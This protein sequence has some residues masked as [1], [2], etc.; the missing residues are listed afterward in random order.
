MSNYGELPN[1]PPEVVR[2]ILRNLEK[3]K[4]SLLNAMKTCRMWANVGEDL[5]WRSVEPRAFKSCSLP[6]R[7]YYLNKIRE[8][9]L[10]ADECFNGIVDV[11]EV[12]GMSFSPLLSVRIQIVYKLFPGNTS[13]PRPLG[14]YQTLQRHQNNI[15]FQVQQPLPARTPLQTLLQTL[16][17]NQALQNCVLSRRVSEHIK[18]LAIVGTPY[19]WPL[20][21]SAL[22]RY[23]H[24]ET[25]E[26]AEWEFAEGEMQAGKDIL[27][28][29]ARM[30]IPRP[31]FRHLILDADPYTHMIHQIIRDGVE[32]DD[33][34][35][36]FDQ[37]VYP[38]PFCAK[39]SSCIRQLSVDECQFPAGAFGIIGTMTT[40]ESVSI[41]FR[42]FKEE[43]KSS[44][45]HGCTLAT[46]NSLAILRSLRIYVSNKAAAT[47]YATSLI[48][49]VMADLL[50][51]I[52]YLEEIVFLLPHRFTIKTLVH[53]GQNCRFLKTCYLCGH[54]DLPN[55]QTG[56]VS[57]LYPD[58]KILALD[59]IGSTLNHADIPRFSCEIVRNIQE[60]A[61]SLAAFYLC[62][63]SA[64]LEAIWK[65]LYKSAV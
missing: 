45:C 36:F 59:G 27:G 57:I 11:N 32:S 30:L 6:R 38:V 7:A 12:E 4:T 46:L 17:P 8:L 35:E 19:S 54:F 34:G 64:L 65:L 49:E 39:L 5:L 43:P 21:L 31:S 10:A 22:S 37:R 28:R 48:D 24:L 47:S 20:L 63:Q 2:L 33:W 15:P 14:L 50:A 29:I 40:L 1:T 53:L 55:L 60:H 18:R 3:D 9:T 44:I 25:V 58:L 13:M 16:N 42:D 56:S 41:T 26:L 62:E 23:R 51:G 52:R 61:P